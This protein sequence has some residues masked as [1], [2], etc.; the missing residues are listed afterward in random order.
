MFEILNGV[1]RAKAA[2]LHGVTFVVAKVYD[3]D[4][5]LV[6]LRDVPLTDL[7]SPKAV[8]D[9]T[10]SALEAIRFRRLQ[11]LLFAGIVL[12]PIEVTPGA[13][14]TPIPDVMVIT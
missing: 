10:A 11:S 1:R 2:E 12:D 4:G 13:T 14:G 9:L 7:R 6:E 8:L 3:T 5:R